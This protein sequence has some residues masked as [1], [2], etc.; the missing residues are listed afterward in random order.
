MNVQWE[1]ASKKQSND[2][3][4]PI[5]WW[6]RWK[7]TVLCLLLLF[8]THSFRLYW[9]VGNLDEAIKSFREM[10]VVSFVATNSNFGYIF[11][12]LIQFTNELGRS[13]FFYLQYIYISGPLNNYYVHF[14]W[15]PQRNCKRRSMALRFHPLNS[16]WLE[17]E[18]T[19][20]LRLVIF[21]FDILRVSCDYFF[22]LVI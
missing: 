7:M 10:S 8:M 13:H 14:K 20:T 3:W 6:R 22:A 15:F 19:I 21:E 2:G 9:L 16:N 4:R 12:L 11:L 17:P 18:V 5:K 1:M